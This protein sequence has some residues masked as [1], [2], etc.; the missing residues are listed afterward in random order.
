MEWV[1]KILKKCNIAISKNN[2]FICQTHKSE[3][4]LL[5]NYY[6]LFHFRTEVWI[7][8]KLLIILVILLP[9]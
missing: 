1:Q 7:H 6:Y 2:A 4:T 5:I 9:L 3:C 8:A